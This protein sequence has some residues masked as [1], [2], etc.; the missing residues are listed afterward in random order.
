MESK[1]EDALPAV[2]RPLVQ[3]LVQARIKGDSTCFLPPSLHGTDEEQLFLS[4]LLKQYCCSGIGYEFMHCATDAERQFFISAVEDES[5]SDD[6]DTSLQ[7]C[8]EQVSRAGAWERLL[9]LRYPT[10]KRF[11]LEGLESGVLA[12]NTVLDTFANDNAGSSS[13]FNRAIISTLHRGRINI[14]HTILQNSV[15][16]LLHKWDKTNGPTYDDINEGHS[17]DICTRRGHPLHI[18]LMAMPAHLESQDAAVAGKARGHM[19]TRILSERHESSPLPVEMDEHIARAVLPIAVHGDS[20][21]CGQG[22]VSETLQLSTFAGYDCG[23]TLHLIFNNQIGFTAET[24]SMRT[25]RHGLVNVSDLALSIRA[26][27]L[28]VNAE[29]PHDVFHA[30]RL[31]TLYRQRFGKDIVLD[32]WGYRRHGHNEVDEPNITNVSLYQE[33]ERHAPTEQVLLSSCIDTV[34]RDY[35]QLMEQVEGEYSNVPATRET[36]DA[37][38]DSSDSGVPPSTSSKGGEWFDLWSHLSSVDGVTGVESRELKTALATLSKV[39]DGF[40]LSKPTQRAVSRRGEFLERLGKYEN[41]MASPP[42]IDWATAELLALSTLAQE[43]RFCRL[44]GQDTQ[45]G[46]FCQ[47]HAVWHDIVTGQV[48]HALPELVQVLNSPLSELGVLGF[49]HGISLASPNFLVLW[50]AQFGDFVNNSQVLIDTMISSEKDKFGLESNWILLLPHGYDG[51]GPEHSSSRLERFLTLHTDTPEKTELFKDD[52]E[53]FRDS[54]FTVVYPSTPSNYFHVLR[55]SFSWPFRRPMVVLTPKRSL[56]L[57][58][59]VSPLTELL[60]NGSSPGCFSAVLDDPRSLEHIHV[61]SIALC[62]GEIFYDL[63][64]LVQSIPA[65]DLSQKVAI[66]RV[67][68]LAPFPLRQLQE[69]LKDYPQARR[70]V[71]VQEEP[72]NMGA[73]RFTAPFLA[74]LSPSIELGRA[75]SRP[76]SAAPAVGSPNEHRQSQRDLLSRFAGW[77]QEG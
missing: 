47:R 31:A 5:L 30:A 28:H 24:Q 43:G 73:L 49:E 13:S 27:V 41:G 44:S 53:R 45:R 64:K 20:S 61:E 11:S 12:L 62:S 1:A 67:E 60:R 59:A 50:E 76:V 38:Q 18:S 39:P 17:V 16:T 26:P 56:R 72:A 75:I 6:D 71:W 46:T 69:T 23:G 25:S 74:K 32:I 65:E 33:I 2:L 52:I 58:D 68:Q 15:D 66:L 40:T 3:H 54:N 70:A 63:L 29:R 36:P 55:R 34:R 19:L 7:F 8:V 48:H 22:I 37:Q 4:D 51:M 57:P 9:G 21:F 77:I 10:C 35:Q 14:L 42:V